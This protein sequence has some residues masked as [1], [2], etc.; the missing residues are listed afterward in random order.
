MSYTSVHASSG[1]SSAIFNINRSN[2]AA[3]SSVERLASG[4]RIVQAGD[5]VAGLSV[6]TGLMSKLAALRASFSNATQG[7]SMLQ[8]AGGGVTQILDMLI[9]QKALAVQAQSG[10]LTSTERGYLDQSFQALSEQINQIANNTTFDGVNLLNGGLGTTTRLANTDAIAAAFTPA[11]ATASAGASTASS[12]AIQAFTTL[13][14][15]S[16][17]GT[18]AVG[19]MDIVDAGGTVLTNAAF[20]GV[21]TALHGQFSGFSITNVNFGV[22]ADVNATINGVTFTGTVAHNATTA[23]LH[24]GNTY[25]KMG[26]GTLNLTNAATVENSRANWESGFANT[27][28]MHTALVQGVN[29]TGTA[30]SGVTGAATTGV[31]MARVSNPSEVNISN[32]RYLGSTGADGNIIAVD[33]NGTTFTA[34]GVS[35]LVDDGTAATYSFED[36]SG[37]ALTLNITG[38]TSTLTN[39]R[40]ST[41][42]RQQFID[43]LNVGFSRAGG[44]LGFDVN[45]NPASPVTVSWE[46]ATTANLY[47]GQSLDVATTAT[48]G[49][50]E[51]A[52]DAAIAKA[53]SIQAAIGAQQ[54]QLDY[55]AANAESSMIG[56]DAARS[57]LLDTDVAEESTF[58]AL[59]Q[60]KQQTG[61]AAL[62]QINKMSENM[63][64]LVS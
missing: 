14:G 29:F 57:A 8:V 28:L 62:A 54:T 2:K 17:S 44:G 13:G 46:S 33:V 11:T 52:L 51:T 21:N 23:T 42:D 59:A 50:T 47:N 40:T 45:A 6:G 22:A 38:M 12:K 63:L 24:N 64:K 1:A 27:A 35:D 32:F 58:L 31:A 60:V 5:D 36:G 39:I 53:T 15:T 43:A 19:K 49:T 26:T 18:A 9:E 56:Q 10:S 61:V 3:A 25:I 41:T 37:Q 48:A 16:M 4:K 20:D 34:T 7:S 30:L 55:A